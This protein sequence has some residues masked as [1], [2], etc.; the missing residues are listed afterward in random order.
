[1]K[2]YHEWMAWLSG[3]LILILALPVFLCC[4]G[5][6]YGVALLDKLEKF[7]F[8]HDIEAV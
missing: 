1:M 3:L 5:A 8:H 6:H 4:I 2:I 7:Q